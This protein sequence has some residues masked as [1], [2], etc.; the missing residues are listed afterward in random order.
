MHRFIKERYLCFLKSYGKTRH[1]ESIMIRINQNYVVFILHTHSWFYC[2]D[3]V[4]H[5][6]LKIV[7]MF[8]FEFFHQ[9]EGFSSQI[10]FLYS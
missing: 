5:V 1:T 6:T 3:S 4:V 2:Y 9:N 8:V 7:K 10:T